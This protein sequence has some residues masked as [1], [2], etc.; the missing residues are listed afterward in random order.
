MNS[1][2]TPPRHLAW[3]RRPRALSSGLAF[4][5]ALAIHSDT[6]TKIHTYIHIYIH[7][8]IYLYIYTYTHIHIYTS[9]HLPLRI[10][11]PIPIP[12]HMYIYMRVCVCSYIYIYVCV[13]ACI[14][15]FYLHTKLHHTD[16]YILPM[17]QYMVEFIL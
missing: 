11:I 8:F 17:I 6:V 16:P 5:P 2:L 15:V 12:I 7:L 13:Y 9:T 10:P 1:A 4:G 3:A 14:H